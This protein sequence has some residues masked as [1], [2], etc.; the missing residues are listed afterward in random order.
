MTPVQYLNVCPGSDAPET[1]D[2][3]DNEWAIHRESGLR[4]RILRGET[5]LKQRYGQ[6]LF[7]VTDGLFSTCFLY[8]EWPT[9]YQPIRQGLIVFSKLFPVGAAQV[10]HWYEVNG[11]DGIPLAEITSIYPLR[12]KYGDNQYIL[13]ASQLGECLTA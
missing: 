10:G 3:L 8:D 12:G 6:F 2:M 4:V 9:Y 5:S 1:I 13:E 11:V 7:E